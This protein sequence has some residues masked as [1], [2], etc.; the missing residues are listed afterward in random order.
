MREQKK[1]VLW[2]FSKNRNVSPTIAWF[3]LSKLLSMDTKTKKVTPWIMTFRVTK[4]NPSFL[5][6]GTQKFN[7]K[8]LLNWVSIISKKYALFPIIYEALSFSFLPITF[9]IISK[10]YKLFSINRFLYYSV[11]HAC[12]CLFSI[13]NPWLDKHFEFNTDHDCTYQTN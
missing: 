4:K 12:Y 13:L 8:M 9:P 11:Q 7:T 1:N 5:F 3:N 6:S 10:I 2:K